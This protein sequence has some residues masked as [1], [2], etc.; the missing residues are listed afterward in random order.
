[1]S[2]ALETLQGTFQYFFTKYVDN[3]VKICYHENEKEV[4]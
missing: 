2:P 3:I 1:M 4:I